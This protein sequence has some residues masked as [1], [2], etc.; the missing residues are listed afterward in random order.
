[1]LRDGCTHKEVAE[2]LGINEKTVRRIVEKAAE[3]VGLAMPA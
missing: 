1:M 3:G 2:R